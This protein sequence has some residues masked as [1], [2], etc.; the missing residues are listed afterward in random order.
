M[1]NGYFQYMN[2]FPE[3]AILQNRLGHLLDT[4]M[5]LD[6]NLVGKITRLRD[7]AARA[8][9]GASL[10]VPAA[11][12]LLGRLRPGDH[13]VFVTGCAVRPGLVPWLGEPDG[14]CGVAALARALYLATGAV[15]TVVIA[16]PLA[17]QAQAALRSAGATV[18][19][20][21]MLDAVAAQPRVTFCAAVQPF[22]PD[23][24]HGPAMTALIDRLRPAAVLSVEHLGRASDGQAYFSTGVP[25][26]GDVLRS[27]PL[28]GRAA[29][30]GALLLS[31][32]DNANEA[33]TAAL[34]DP[35]HDHFPPIARAFDHVL[36]GTTANWAA[37]ALTAALAALAGR[38][39]ATVDGRFDMNGVTATLA[40]G[41]IDPFGGFADPEAG[42]D[43]IE[44]R[45]HGLVVDL[46]AR[47]AH[48]FID[49]R[50]FTDSRLT[51]SRGA[52]A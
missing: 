9:D 34:H 14:P 41:A 30:H 23:T 12:A 37:Y 28:F 19:A 26:P 1:A 39:D 3:P 6:L 35:A 16:T 10:T 44:G 4:L 25:F 20:Q 11:A 18:V 46:M 21:E 24:D 32:L 51:D 31:C 43:T 38:P 36:P 13:V 15:S 40:A 42:T 45:Y 47:A 5:T 49:A 29:E 7:A 2:Y 22:S 48:G 50:R 8:V 52:S 27:D 17:P 33:G